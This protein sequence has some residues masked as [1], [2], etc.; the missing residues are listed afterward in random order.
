VRA[1]LTVAEDLHAAI[2]GS[3][4]VVLPEAG[5]ICNIEAPEEFN[6]A[7]RDFLRDART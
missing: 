1:P 2:S 4:L 3:K 7:V 5:H 6:T